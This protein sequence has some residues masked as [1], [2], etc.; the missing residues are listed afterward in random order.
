MAKPIAIDNDDTLKYS[1]ETI[2]NMQ[3]K[4]ILELHKHSN[5]K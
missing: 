2:S 5:N 3:T 4:E 1:D